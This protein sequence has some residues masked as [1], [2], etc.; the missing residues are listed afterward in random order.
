MGKLTIGE[1]LK[2]FINHWAWLAYL[3]SAGMTD[4]EFQIAHYEQAMALGDPRTPSPTN[5]NQGE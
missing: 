4:E 2:E 5:L 1:R 3:W